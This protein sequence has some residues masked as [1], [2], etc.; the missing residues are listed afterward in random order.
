M[1][2]YICERSKKKNFLG[3]RELK[4]EIETLAN[5]KKNQNFKPK[6]IVIELGELVKNNLFKVL[7]KILNEI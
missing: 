7:K 3:K 4:K 5:I 1:K 2:N 6:L